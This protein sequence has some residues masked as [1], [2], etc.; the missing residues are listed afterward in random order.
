MT[1]PVFKGGLVA[2]NHRR[3]SVPPKTAAPIYHSPEFRRWREAVI[4]RAGRQCEDDLAALG[5]SI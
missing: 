1:L 3:L 4:A 2:F 5:M